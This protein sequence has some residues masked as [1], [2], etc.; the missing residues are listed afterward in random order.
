MPGLS[1][2]QRV[3]REAKAT[4][5]NSQAT[6]SDP[7]A[8]AQ[9]HEA[10]VLRDQALSKGLTDIA[11]QVQ[12]V[13]DNLEAQEKVLRDAEAASDLA[14]RRAIRSIIKIRDQF[15]SDDGSDG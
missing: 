12:G 13:I 4:S 10:R 8:A 9:L 5:A 11:T 2:L 6:L 3:T 1:A 15:G 7:A 14:Q